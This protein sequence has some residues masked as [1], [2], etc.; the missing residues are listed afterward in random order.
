VPTNIFLPASSM[1]SLRVSKSLTRLKPYIPNP[2][3]SSFCVCLLL[4]ISD[5]VSRPSHISQIESI[6]VPHPL[7]RRVTT[8]AQLIRFSKPLGIPASPGFREL[9]LS[10]FWGSFRNSFPSTFKIRISD[11]GSICQGITH[12]FPPFLQDG[13]RGQQFNWAHTVA[14]SISA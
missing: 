5:L 14:W 4:I 8:S 1:L 12:R 3:C 13:D 2:S 9:A 10:F 7:R 11:Q 6:V